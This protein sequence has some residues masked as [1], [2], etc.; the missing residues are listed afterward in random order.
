MEVS[1]LGIFS[2]ESFPITAIGDDLIAAETFLGKV[3][4]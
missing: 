1:I 4:C 3:I 2:E